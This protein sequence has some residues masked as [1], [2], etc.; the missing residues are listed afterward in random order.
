[1]KSIGIKRTLYLPEKAL[2]YHLHNNNL[3]FSVLHNRLTMTNR[4]D[5]L[6]KRSILYALGKTPQNLPIV[7]FHLLGRNERV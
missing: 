1:M 4:Q 2:I 7:L 6:K 5:R 3:T